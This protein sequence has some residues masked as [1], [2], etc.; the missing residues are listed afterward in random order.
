MKINRKMTAIT[1]IAVWLGIMC[2]LQ[3]C[4]HEKMPPE[5][6]LDS[7]QYHVESGTN[8]LKLRKYD[9]ALREFERS[10]ELDPLFSRAYVGSGLVWGHKGDYKKGIK[11]IEKAK[12][13]TNTDNDKVFACV[14]LIRLY[15]TGKESAHKEWLEKAESAYKAAVALLPDFSEAHYYMGQAYKE[16]LNFKKARQLFNKVLEI[17]N[18]CVHEA[19]RALSLIE[20]M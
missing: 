20:N 3:G 9:D 2:C 19:R 7:P 6:A 18:T 5:Y 4:T 1:L 13:L 17:N 10:K 12:T 14:G 16:A 8:L 15:L 11:D